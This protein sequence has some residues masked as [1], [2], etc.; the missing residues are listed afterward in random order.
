MLPSAATASRA[1]IPAVRLF[2]FL[3]DDFVLKYQTKIVK[4]V[5]GKKIITY[6]QALS[7]MRIRDVDGLKKVRFVPNSVWK[8]LEMVRVGMMAGF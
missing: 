5:S 7:A 4:I 1:C 6:H 2:L 8:R 3:R